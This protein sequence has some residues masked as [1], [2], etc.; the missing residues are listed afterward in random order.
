[1]ANTVPARLLALERE[2]RQVVEAKYTELRAKAQRVANLDVVYG[3]ALR[4][5]NDIELKTAQAN[6]WE[7]V[8]N[9]REVL[10]DV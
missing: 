8:G 1:M 7:A 5:G 4:A 3:E 2:R 10:S 6:I 9:L